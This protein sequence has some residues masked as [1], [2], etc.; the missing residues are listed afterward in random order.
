MR[1]HKLDLCLP[2]SDAPELLDRFG[3]AA[4]ILPPPGAWPPEVLCANLHDI[5]RYNRL[6]GAHALMMRLVHEVLGEASSACTGL[7]VGTGLGDFIAY[8]S[9]YRVGQ[10]CWVGLD[11][12]WPVLQCARR[13]RD[14]RHWPL[15]L[16]AGQR[17]PCA[18]ECF[19]VVTVAQT[20][21]HLAPPE[22]VRLLGECA[23]VARRGVVVVDLARGYLGLAGAWLLTRLTSRNP[24]TRADGVQSV[25]RAYTPS[26]AL[27]LARQAG[28]VGAR[29]HQRGPIRYAL[30]WRRA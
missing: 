24:L 5:A 29:V 15:L 18:D 30:V 3:A 7:D 21:H 4:D 25:R 22:A 10:S 14:A 6:L 17:L 20:L 28:W 11:S 9:A 26:E 13:A 2:R 1:F 8:A 27:A 16:G 12:A 23:R 19:D